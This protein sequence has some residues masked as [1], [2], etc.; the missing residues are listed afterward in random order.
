MKV[1]EG[2][3]FFLKKKNWNNKTWSLS[4]IFLSSDWRHVTFLN[5][6]SVQNNHRHTFQWLRYNFSIHLPLLKSG[7][8][9]TEIFGCLPLWVSELILHELIHTYPNTFWLLKTWLLDIVL[10]MWG[11]I[12][13]NLISNIYYQTVKRQVKTTWTIHRIKYSMC[14]SIPSLFSSISNKKKKSICWDVKAYIP[15][16]P[17]SH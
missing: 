2:S 12:H 13:G 4:Y 17:W 6:V 14:N 11:S 15:Y 10:E 3:T 16:W 8:N 9:N 7:G 5:P 1:N